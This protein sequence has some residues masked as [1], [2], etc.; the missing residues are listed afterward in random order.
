MYGSVRRN[1]RNCVIERRPIALNFIIYNPH[2]NLT[3]LTV[4]WFRND[5]MARAASS[6]EEI[7][8]IQ[9]EYMLSQDNA[10][11]PSL[12]IGN[13]INC[14]AGPLYRDTYILVIHNFTSDK[15]GYYWC[16]IYVNN[17]ISQPSQYAWFYA[18]DSSSCTQQSHFKV[19]NEPQ[20]AYVHSDTNQ[21][22]VQMPQET[23]TVIVTL[24][25][26]TQETTSTSGT[27]EATSTSVTT[28]ATSTSVTV[29]ATSTS[30]TVETTS[31]SATIEAT[32]KI[33]ET[34]SPNTFILDEISHSTVTVT[35]SELTSTGTL[36]MPEVTATEADSSM[37]NLLYIIVFL[38][39]FILLLLSL[40]ILI[41]LCLYC[42]ERKKDCQK[43]GK[44]ALLMN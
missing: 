12:T 44:Y 1:A 35:D 4:R 25:S 29:E 17:S 36:T 15:N 40:F 21:V 27:I 22:S 10:S 32:S 42:K 37:D 26:V 41:L 31:T 18:A 16:Q 19:T 7:K 34:P 28:K 38:V 8:H 20:C 13:N 5:N 9:R 30:V 23:S 3:N 14:F 33:Q 11:N 43:S 2:D 39:V 24:T 6:N